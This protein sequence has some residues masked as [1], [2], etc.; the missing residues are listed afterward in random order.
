MKIYPITALLLTGILLVTGCTK[1]MKQINEEVDKFHRHYNQGE[2]S[3]IYYASGKEYQKATSVSKHNDFF[4]LVNKAL[5]RYQ[6]KQQT[7]YN[8]HYQN[9]I[10]TVTVIYQSKFERGEGEELFVF[11]QDKR[12]NYRLIHYNVNTK[13]FLKYGEEFYKVLYE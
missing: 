1:N 12:K 8:T 3:T 7:K 10:N 5:G 9:G 2:Y 11:L 6:S 13:E 4:N